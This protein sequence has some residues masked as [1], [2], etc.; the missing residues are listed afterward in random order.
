MSRSYKTQKL[1]AWKAFSKYI[2]LRDADENGYCKCISCGKKAW[3]QEM[4]AGHLIASRANS[5]LF[6]EELVYAQCPYCNNNSGE[7]ASYWMGL[8]KLKG[9][10][11]SKFDEFKARK[12][13]TK[14][15]KIWELAEIEEKYTDM[16]IGEGMKRG[17]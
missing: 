2:R 15:Y 8:K 6:D 16:A 10:P 11:D 7:Q 5:I 3:W 4:Q 14:K 17:L 9:Y 13:G 1:Y 12:N